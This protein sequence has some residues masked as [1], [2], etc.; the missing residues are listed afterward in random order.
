[1]K[2]KAI[3]ALEVLTLSPDSVIVEDVG[4]DIANDRSA[5]LV[6]LDFAAPDAYGYY[7]SGTFYYVGENKK[8]D[9]TMR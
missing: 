1:M 5:V 3:A 6:T 4:Y 9:F 2:N 8:Y 7:S